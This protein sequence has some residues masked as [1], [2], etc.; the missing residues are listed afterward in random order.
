MNSSSG[1]SPARNFVA[2][3]LKSSNSRCED[4]DHVPGHVLQ[5]LG[6][7]ERAAP[8]GM[9]AGSI[10]GILLD[11]GAWPGCSRPALRAAVDELLR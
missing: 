10:V 8:A 3:V 11:P 4:R 6:V 9:E 1:V 2:S 7:L 5:D